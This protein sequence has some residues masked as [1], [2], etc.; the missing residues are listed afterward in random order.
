[1]PYTYLLF[2]VVCKDRNASKTIAEEKLPG[3]E[4][5]LASIFY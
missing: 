3:P 1:M 2:L 4:Y 5:Q